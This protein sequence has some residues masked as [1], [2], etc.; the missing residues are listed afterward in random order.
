M[1][2]QSPVAAITDDISRGAVT[3]LA[4]RIKAMGGSPSD[5]ALQDAEL[6]YVIPFDASASNYVLDLKQVSFQLAKAPHAVPLKNNNMFLAAGISMGILRVPVTENAGVVQR[7]NFGNAKL[8]TFVDP[9]VFT[10]FGE[11]DALENIFNAWFTLKIANK[12]VY[13]KGSQCFKVVPLVQTS[14]IAGARTLPS[15][16]YDGKNTRGIIPLGAMKYMSGQDQHEA[17]LSFSAGNTLN[18][19]GANA[20]TTNAAATPSGFRNFLILS[21]TGAQAV[22]LTKAV[23]E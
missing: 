19:D 9:N 7:Y 2:K 22:G 5:Y 4:A 6:S 13:A 3:A 16:N 17:Q 23:T 1:S 12:E 20:T 11:A 14:T 18:I 8:Y 15:N 21:F 10:G